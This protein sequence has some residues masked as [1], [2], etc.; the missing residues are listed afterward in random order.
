[1]KPILLEPEAFTVKVISIDKNSILKSTFEQLK[2]YPTYK[3][4]LIGEDLYGST[5]IEDI[6]CKTFL[7][8]KVSN[9]LY[10]IQ[11]LC[12]EQDAAYFRIVEL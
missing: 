2:D 6:L 7:N 3:D 12:V 1:M 5:V 4:T 11:E 9:E 10:L 8:A